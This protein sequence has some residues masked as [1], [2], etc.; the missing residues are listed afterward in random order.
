MS[1]QG[2]RNMADKIRLGL[3]GA[4]V[5]GT[6]SARAHLPALQ[7]SSDVELAAVCTTRADSAEAARQAYGARLA[8]DDYHKMI[9]S[10]E[11]DAVAVV[12][13]VPSHYAPTKAA[14]EAGKHV[15]CEWP[16]GRT[17]EEATE[18]ARLAKSM[19]VVTTVG[20]QA[21]VH[22][23][24]MYM[25]ELVEGGFVGEVMAIHVSLITEGI[26][27]KPPSRMWQWDA[28]AG[29][30]TLTIAN[31][32]TLDAMRFVAGEIQRF[33][34]VVATQVKQ[35]FDTSVNRLIDVTAPDNVL[36]SGRLAKGAVASLH[37]AAV[38]FNGSG[39][40]MEVYGREG[41]L[42]ASGP[43]SPQMSEVFLH[44]AKG[45]N[46]MEPMAVPGRF[47]GAAHGMP[48]AESINVG[49]MYS[50]FAE[51]IHGGESRQPTF[52]TAVGLHRLLD[53][54]RQASASGQDV[55]FA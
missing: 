18:L 37:V 15:Y 22:P 50:L 13:R 7:A 20:L 33:S 39:Y 28:G 35:W 6:W 42:L 11:I 31:G 21:R 19:G 41:T 38:P 36:V 16:L 34:A 1:F 25:K 32:H 5:K 10:P 53:A 46:T 8:F 52:E 55:T 23:T 47:A 48:F 17:T 29:A 2:G 43:E 14:L 24:L 30:N 12:V 26:L 49:R 44:G 54:I 9:A 45:G 27:S 51:A 40:R 3:I 4:S